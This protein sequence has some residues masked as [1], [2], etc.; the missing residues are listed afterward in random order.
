[1]RKGEPAFDALVADMIKC[2]R[3]MQEGRERK[4]K[5]EGEGEGE[6]GEEEGWVLVEEK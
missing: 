4:G 5:G 6:E 2:G 1:M 3:A